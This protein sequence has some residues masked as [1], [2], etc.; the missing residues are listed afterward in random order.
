M[1]FFERFDSVR[2]AAALQLDRRDVE[3]IVI[4]DGERGHGESM[5]PGRGV[6]IRFERLAPGGDVEHAI[7]LQFLAG[8]K[9]RIEMSAMEGIER[10]ADDADSHIAG[11]WRIAASSA[12]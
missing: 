11:C 10:A 1:Q 6:A 3:R 5:E 2:N 4:A 12:S 7:P 9:D 8:G